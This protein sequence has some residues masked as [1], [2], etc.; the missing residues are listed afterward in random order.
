MFSDVSS[1]AFKSVSIFQTVL[2]SMFISI[3]MYMC[4]GQCLPCGHCGTTVLLRSG[5]I[6]PNGIFNLIGIKTC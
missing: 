2:C 3:F 1:V 4:A 5:I 6:V